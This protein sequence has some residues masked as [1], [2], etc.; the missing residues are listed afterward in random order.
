MVIS[1]EEVYEREEWVSISSTIS[2]LLHL[3]AA[4]AARSAPARTAAARRQS[5][6]RETH[7]KWTIE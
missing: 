7:L 6:I 1:M 2:S 4:R 5:V 3:P